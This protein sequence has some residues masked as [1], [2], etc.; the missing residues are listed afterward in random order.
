ME[1]KQAVAHHKRGHKTKELLFSFSI[2]LFLNRNDRKWPHARQI[3]I[4][5]QNHILPPLRNCMGN[6]T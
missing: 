6:E 2:I 5:G 1:I 3:K 4:A